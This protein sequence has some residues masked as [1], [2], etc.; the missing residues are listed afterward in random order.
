MAVQLPA[1]RA[2]QSVV[3][4][5]PLR[6][7]EDIY[8]RMGQLMDA[9]FADF[10]RG[11]FRSDMPWSPMADVS[12]TDDAFLVELD[13][14]NARKDQIDVQISDRMLM[15][16]GEIPEQKRE[17]RHHRGRRTGRFEYRV[18]LPGEVNADKV[19]AQLSDG[20][21]TVTVPK[22]QKTKPRHIKVS[23]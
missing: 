17:R 16:T 7:F 13:V 12:E 4:L 6:E 10:T 3:P 8:D 15:I 2:T 1:Q 23:T 14:P 9:A 11:Q 21:L 5:S 18:Q 20:V 19:N 22:A